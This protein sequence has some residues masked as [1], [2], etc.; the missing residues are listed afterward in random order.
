MTEQFTGD[1]SF[2]AWEA[3]ER[4]QFDFLLSRMR[5]V[6]NPNYHTPDFFL[7]GRKAH[8]H[9][10]H[11]V[12]DGAPIDPVIVKKEVAFV[13]ELVQTQAAKYVEEKWGFTN[14]WIVMP[15]GKAALRVIIDV[16]LD[17]D[18]E[19]EVIDWK[20]GQKRDESVEQMHLMATATFH[21][22][23]AVETVTTRLVYITKGG[24]SLKDHYRRD[25]LEM[26]QTWE[27]RFAKVYKETEWRPRPSEWCRFCEHARAK[28]GVCRYG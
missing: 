27:S 13:N 11:V 8:T 25:L 6:K 1:M 17:Y 22:Y 14:G 4:C 3:F 19:V 2:S 5:K 7:D 21:R 28:G 18:N 24:Q 26:T 23:P 9:L 10:E 20:T 15:Y 12:R 16:R